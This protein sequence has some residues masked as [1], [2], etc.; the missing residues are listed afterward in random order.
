MILLAVGP[1]LVA[2]SWFGVIRW[3]DWRQRDTWEDV[4][5]PGA[6]EI[7]QYSITCTF[8]DDGNTEDSL[9]DGLREGDSQTYQ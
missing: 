8:D 1:P 3:H 5:G 6:I 9:L 2:G 7:L 4:G